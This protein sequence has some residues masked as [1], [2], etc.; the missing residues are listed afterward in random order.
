MTTHHATDLLSPDEEMMKMCI[1]SMDFYLA[2]KK[3]KVMK[4]AGRWIEMENIYIILS[5]VTHSER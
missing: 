4:C 2:V 3:I 1:C 5:Q